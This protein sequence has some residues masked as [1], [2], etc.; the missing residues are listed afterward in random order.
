MQDSHEDRRVDEPGFPSDTRR[1][2]GPWLR[3]LAG[4][5]LAAAMAGG[6]AMVAGGSTAAA[7]ALILRPRAERAMLPGVP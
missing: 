6:A 2:L 7:H 5:C 4:I 1:R 3:A